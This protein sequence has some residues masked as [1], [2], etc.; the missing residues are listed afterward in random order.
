MTIIEKTAGPDGAHRLQSQSHRTHNWMGDG[1]LEVPARIEPDVWACGGYCELNV[2]NGALTGIIPGGK[3][4][5]V[6][7]PTEEEDTGA[8]LVDH[9]YRLTLLE[10]GVSGEVI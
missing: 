3:P 9:E 1:W 2:E 7:S 10:L 5:P 4:A 6:P 8:M